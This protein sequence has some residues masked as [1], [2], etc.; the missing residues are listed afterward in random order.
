MAEAIAAGPLDPLYGRGLLPH[1]AECAPAPRAEGGECFQAFGEQC[2]VPF[3]L[4][5]N[6]Y[7][8]GSCTRTP[9]KELNRAGWG[10][11][12]LDCD[13]RPVRQ[14]SGPVWASLPQTSQAAEFAAL[15]ALVQL[16]DGPCV[17]YSDCLGVVRA[18]SD[19]ASYA[20]DPRKMYAAVLRGVMR[21]P[22]LVHVLAV[23]KVKAHQTKAMLT[24]MPAACRR[25]AAGND[26]ADAAADVGRRAHP[27]VDH[28]VT[29][30]RGDVKKAGLVLQLL[31]EAL[32]LWPKPGRLPPRRPTTASVRQGAVRASASMMAPHCWARAAGYWRCTRCLCSIAVL[33]RDDPASHGALCPGPPS[34]FSRLVASGNGHSVVVA[35]TTSGVPLAVCLRCGCW[36]ARRLRGLAE[37]C[38]G[39]ASPGKRAVLQRMAARQHPDPRAAAAGVRLETCHALQ[40]WS[41]LDAGVSFPSL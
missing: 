3:T 31:A 37:R 30:L 35:H 20:S 6:V 28:V 25:L 32:A 12:Q 2:P 27:M 17:A 5:G 41:F 18:M 1:P 40:A 7:I 26:A 19:C 9:C 29:K 11:V 22:G 10:I 36:S 24:D 21:D 13:G 23:L 15:A 4:E 34:I 38:S 8:D 14:A 16:L 33:P 39:P